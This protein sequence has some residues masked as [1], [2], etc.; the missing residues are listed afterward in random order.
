MIIAGRIGDFEQLKEQKPI[1]HDW[2]GCQKGLVFSGSAGA[3]SIFKD[4]FSSLSYSEKNY[5]LK[6]G[7]AYLVDQ[8]DFVKIKPAG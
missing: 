7:E 1:V 4:S 6:E 2:I 3:H 5:L 8:G